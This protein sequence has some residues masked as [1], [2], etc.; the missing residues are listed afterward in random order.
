MAL[1]TL[2]PL[3]TL[4]V[5]EVNALIVR[6]ECVITV[7]R[8]QIYH[9]Q[10]E[11]RSPSF[12]LWSGRKK[13]HFNP[14]FTLDFISVYSASGLLLCQLMDGGGYAIF[15][16]FESFHCGPAGKFTGMTT[17]LHFSS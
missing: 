4:V 16:H 9:S 15:M 8:D 6:P 12:S 10:Q 2:L 7:R 11:L 5:S 17:P 14:L 1:F 13:S 3:F